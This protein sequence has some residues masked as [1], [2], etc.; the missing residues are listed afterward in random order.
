MPATSLEIVARC[1]R[2]FEAGWW[3]DAFKEV[4]EAQKLGNNSSS[5]VF[6]RGLQADI[7]G[8][9]EGAIKDYQYVLNNQPNH[10]YA[11]KRLKKLIP[12]S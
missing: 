6:L 5:L 8:K 9:T 10:L 3:E 4:E 11:L 7:T 2:L 12:A 1:L